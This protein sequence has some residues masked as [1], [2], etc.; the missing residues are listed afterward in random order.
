MS[1]FSTILWQEQVTFW[2][3]DEH[4]VR[5]A[6]DQHTKL[7]FYS[8]RSLKQQSVSRHVTPLGHTSLNPIQSVFALITP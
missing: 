7:N 8:G 4:D 1:T 6:L 2:W 5:L 3:D